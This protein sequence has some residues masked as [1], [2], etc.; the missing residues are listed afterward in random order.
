MWLHNPVTGEI[1]HVRS[2]TDDGGELEADLWLQPGAALARPHVHDHLV[3]RFEVLE[4]EVA[5]RIGETDRVARPGDGAFEVPAGTVHD[6][7]NAGD[8]VAHVRG[9][10]RATRAASGRPAARFVSTLECLW[11]LA[12]LGRVD[13]RGVPDPLWLMAIAREYRDVIR[14]TSPP[15]VVQS[16]LAPPI[17][18]L[19]RRTGRDPLAPALH[20][21]EAACAIADPGEEGLRAMLAEAVGASAARDLTSIV[22]AR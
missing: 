8:G 21:P 12:A 15:A 5:L 18:A 22:N 4:G 19:A 1:A 6:W 7:W 3:E 16:V 2:M 9:D 13:A 14:F 10:V 11:S 17:A 20:G